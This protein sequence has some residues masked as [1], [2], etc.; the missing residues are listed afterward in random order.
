MSWKEIE[1]NKFSISYDGMYN[2][3]FEYNNKAYNFHIFLSHDMLIK[4]LENEGIPFED[5]K[6]MDFFDA[7]K[8]EKSTLL[9]DIYSKD[10]GAI[11]FS[12]SGH[13]D[14]YFG[15]EMSGQ[16]LYLVECSIKD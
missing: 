14:N 9:F 11:S 3:E 7:T 1:I 16:P 12:T 4:L 10:N 6:C 13:S 5:A 8:F 2:V 15:Y